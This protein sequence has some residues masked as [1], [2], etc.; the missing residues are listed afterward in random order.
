MISQANISPSTPLGANLVPGGGA[1]FR[2]WAPLAQAVYIN[3]NL[4]G[5]LLTGESDDLLLANNNGYWT[6]FVATAKEG[7]LYRFRVKGQR[8]DAGF[9]RD[10]T[11]GNWPETPN[12]RAA[13]A[14]CVRARNIGGMTRHSLRRISPT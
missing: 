12:S 14:S 3:G 1:T 11:P 2:A 6:G 9:K 10:P 4:G 8:A 5:T 7:D 13:A